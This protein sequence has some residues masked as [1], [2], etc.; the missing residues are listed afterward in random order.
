MIRDVTFPEKLVFLFSPSRYKILHGGRGGAKS[1]AIAR[2]LL[3]MGTQKGIRVL[4]T[5]EVQKSIK[6]SV[7]QL[8]KDQIQRMGMGAD[9]EVLDQE[10]RG[11]TQPD[12]LFLLCRSVRSDGR[13]GQI[14]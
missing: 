6:A 9:Y 10:I 5:R 1:W 7:H 13:D 12:T 11:I 8:L 14:I 3:A 4:C 2:A